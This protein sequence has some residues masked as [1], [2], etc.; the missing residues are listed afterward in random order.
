MLSFDKKPWARSLATTVVLIAS[1]GLFTL[2]ILLHHYNELHIPEVAI[3]ALLLLLLL[4]P[5][6]AIIRQT[7]T[8]PK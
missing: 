8:H 7:P 4:P 2:T 6:I 5:N 1:I 3:I